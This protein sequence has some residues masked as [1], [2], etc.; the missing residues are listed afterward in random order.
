LDGHSVF[1]FPLV[2]ND[3]GSFTRS[4]PGIAGVCVRLSRPSRSA[5]A[6]DVVSAAITGDSQYWIVTRETG[7][8]AGV[9][10]KRAP[11]I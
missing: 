8:F 3:I 5:H 9:G 11:S 7:Q 10:K 2:S 4:S 1:V 6:A